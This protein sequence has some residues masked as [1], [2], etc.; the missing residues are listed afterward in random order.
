MVN[1]KSNLPT[2]WVLLTNAK[3]S[4]VG[5]QCFIVLAV[6]SGF[7]CWNNW[8]YVEISIVIDYHKYYK[9]GDHAIEFIGFSANACP[10]FDQGIYRYQNST[11]R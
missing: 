9:K 4:L 6:H 11:K 8:K 5:C 1:T 2:S 10:G 7:T 3:L